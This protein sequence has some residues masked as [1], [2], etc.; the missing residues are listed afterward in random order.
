M[1]IEGRQGTCNSQMVKVL[2]AEGPGGVEV[3]S[4]REIA[5]PKPGTGEVLIHVRLAAV[6]FADITA[7]LGTNAPPEGF[8]Y[9]HRLGREA[10]GVVAELGEGV[11]GLTV[12]QR[13]AAIFSGGAQA[14]FAVAPAS[15]TYPIPESVSDQ[16]AAA[17][18]VVGM[19]AYHLLC[20]A[21]RAQR[22]ESLLITAAAGGVGTTLIQIARRL[23]LGPVFA[24]AGSSDRVDYA[25]SFGAAAGIDYGSE[26]LANAIA[27]LTGKR[28]IDVVLDA[29]GGTLR[30]DAF[31]AL[32]ALGRLVNYGN[33]SRQPESTYRSETLRGRTV[34]V[35]GFNLAVLLA[36]RPEVVRASFAEA[37]GWIQEGSLRIDV[38]DVM[39]MALAADAH[40]RL[41]A[42]QV[43]GKLLLQF[44]P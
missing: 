24:A 11:Q 39:P 23:Q 12:G 15:S 30:I 17:F 41:E 10:M 6:N 37:L 25:C 14:Q 42:R 9:P 32:T 18:P 19:T 4:V 22:G 27:R 16:Q 21:A 28:G 1:H 26:Q 31:A 43:R 13:I 2:T 40:R 7:R 38:E 20:S 36:Q 5:M 8:E 44:D 34:G 29:V 33:A 3:L 35:I